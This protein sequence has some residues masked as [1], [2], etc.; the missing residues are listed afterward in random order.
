MK[1]KRTTKLLKFCCSFF[2]VGKYMIQQQQKTKNID[3]LY[4][5]WFIEYASYVILERAIPQ[6]NDGLKP[7]QRRILHAM[8]KM[9]DGR[10][11]KVANIIGQTMQYHPHG[12]ASIGD[13]LVNLGQKNLLIDTQ[14]NWGDVNTGDPA[15]APRYIEARL[16]PFA[17]DVLYHDENTEW[18]DS[19]DGRNKEPVTLPVKFP[20]L[21][22]Q[23]VEGIAVGLATKIMPHNIQE[24]I[25]ASIAQLKNQPYQLYPDFPTGGMMD[26]SDY[27]DGQR[28]SKLKIRAK[29]KM[30]DARTLKITEIPYTTT[31]TSLIESIIKANDQGKIKIKKITDRT[32]KDVEIQIELHPG[33]SQH[34]T[35]DA[36]YAFTDCEVTI[37]PNTCVIHDSKPQFLTTSEILAHNTHQTKILLQKELQHQ[38]K[39]VRQ[40]L[41]HLQLEKIFIQNKLYQFIEQCTSWEE[42]VE[43]LQQKLQ[44][45]E[46]TLQQEI[47]VEDITALTEIKFKQITKYNKE[48]SEQTIQKLVADLKQIQYHLDHIVDY[49][50]QYFQTLRQKYAQNYPRKTTFARFEAIE[51]AEVAIN[52]QKLYIN[53]KDGFIGYGL[54]KDEYVQECSELDSIITFHKNGICKV[55]RIAEKAYVGKDIIHAAVWKKNDTTTTYN[56]IYQDTKTNI[57]RAKRFN[58]TSIIYDKEYNITGNCANPKIHFFKV[59]PSSETDIVTIYIHPLAKAINK[60]IEYNF[61]E[62]DIKGRNS[63][64]NLVCK[65]PITKVT[66]KTTN[67]DENITTQYWY[68]PSA[69]KLNTNKHGN[70]LG[71]FAPDD[72]ILALDDKGN[73][74]ITM[75]ETSHY[76]D[77]QH[78]KTIQKLTPSTIITSVYFDGEKQ[79]YYV[80]RF[81]ITTKTLHSPQNYLNDHPKTKYIY[82]TT[83][84]DPWVQMTIQRKRPNIQIQQDIQLNTIIDVKGWKSK[85]N[86]L[87]QQEIIDIKP[88]PSPTPEKSELT[89]QNLDTISTED[90][91]NIK[92]SMPKIA[93]N[94]FKNIESTNKTQETKKQTEKIIEQDPDSSNLNTLENQKNLFQTIESTN[95]TQETKKQTEKIEKQNLDSL[96]LNTLENQKNLFQT[97]ES[98]NKTQETK[99]QTEKIIE[100][101]P[102][103]PNPNT[104]ENLQNLYS[105]F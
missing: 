75:P 22:A 32:A 88:I 57:S 33:T 17:L 58:I 6:L 47:T 81:N 39:Q 79:T 5:N 78:L 44:L 80:K 28:G 7:V 77:F 97:I 27:D 76:Y 94:L 43:T 34:I 85:G 24:L 51:S 42:L 36:L 83:E 21:L 1:F 101:D 52:N 59:N 63:Q 26:I 50:I 95:K 8:K 87:S 90:T 46:K 40:K 100:Q 89:K 10:Y 30:V 62:L 69:G 37:N 86:R 14:G 61:A 105:L 19:Y 70:D 55:T 71:F 64:G 54:K 67:K 102:D 72:T 38:Q 23:G 31:T 2:H 29:I 56:I 66:L 13:A 35:L 53:R 25:D 91:E 12:D 41:H 65:Y 20:L 98:T 15:A 11:H 18:Q 103:S 48:Q 68:D 3:E 84:S 96:N 92:N 60:I 74:K 9:H 82:T 49:T 99:K 4:K 16:T 93:E 73:Y 104:L 45:Y